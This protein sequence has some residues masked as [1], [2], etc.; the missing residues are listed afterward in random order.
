M[1]RLSQFERFEDEIIGDRRSTLIVEERRRAVGDGL[2]LVE[3]DTLPGCSDPFDAKCKEKPIRSRRHRRTKQRRSASPRAA[4]M[5]RRRTNE[6]LGR[7]N[8]LKAKVS[9]QSLRAS[10]EALPMLNV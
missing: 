2:V 10:S 8:E 5:F 1:D 4:P 7:E 3:R 6:I 9:N